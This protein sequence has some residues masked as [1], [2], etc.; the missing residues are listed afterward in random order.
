MGRQ[1]G[2]PTAGQY[3]GVTKDQK[4]YMHDVESFRHFWDDVGAATDSK[5]VVERFLQPVEAKLS[6]LS[7]TMPGISWLRFTVTRQ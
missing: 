6:S 3:D 7:W 2:A 4:M 1:L 5:W